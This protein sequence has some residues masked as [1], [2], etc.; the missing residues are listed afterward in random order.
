MTKVFLPFRLFSSAKLAF[1]RKT[2]VKKKKVNKLRFNISDM[3]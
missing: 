1:L 3:L 2:T